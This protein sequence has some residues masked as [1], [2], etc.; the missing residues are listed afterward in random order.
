MNP[1]LV[2]SSRVG[3]EGNPRKGIPLRVVFIP[4]NRP[5]GHAGL[6]GLPPE[7][8]CF[9]LFCS[10]IVAIVVVVDWIVSG[11]RYTHIGGIRRISLKSNIDLSLHRTKKKMTLHQC[12]IGLL[13]LAIPKCHVQLL[14]S[15]LGKGIHNNS[16]GGHVQPVNDRLVKLINASIV[17][18]GTR[19]GLNGIVYQIGQGWIPSVPGNAQNPAGFV[20]DANVGIAI[21]N[22]ERVIYGKGQGGT[23][24]GADLGAESSLQ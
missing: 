1:E 21:Q 7:L 12:L 15:L 2:G 13:D 10:I 14:Q 3:L 24:F 20:D 19:G 17:A 9:R 5:G 22:L 4:Q 16:T 8:V 6:W 11:L 18:G 23:A